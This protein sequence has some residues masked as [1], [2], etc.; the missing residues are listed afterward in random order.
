MSAGCSGI[1]QQPG[2]GHDLN[3][4]PA[5]NSFIYS[6]LLSW[7]FYFL[8]NDISLHLDYILN[9]KTA[10]KYS[11]KFWKTSTV[12]RQQVHKWTSSR[13]GCPSLSPSSI[14]SLAKGSLLS[15]CSCQTQRLSANL[16]AELDVPQTKIDNFPVGM[17]LKE[18]TKIRT[19]CTF[20]HIEVSTLLQMLQW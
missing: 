8:G 7:W 12:E 13:R 18:K 20:T 9:I 17:V 15:K 11:V 10:K 4:T 6:A 1:S 3:V 14:L 2:T 5:T 16:K 19:G